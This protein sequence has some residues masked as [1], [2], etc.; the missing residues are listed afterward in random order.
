MSFPDLGTVR[1]LDVGAVEGPVD[2][3]VEQDL[4]IG[5]RQQQGGRG[6]DRPESAPGR[7]LRADDAN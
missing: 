6:R 4:S 1:H 7:L 5:G 2:E 3:A